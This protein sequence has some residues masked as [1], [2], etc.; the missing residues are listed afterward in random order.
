MTA[1]IAATTPAADPAIVQKSAA[2]TETI[3]TAAYGA[4]LPSSVGQSRRSLLNEF[5]ERSHIQRC[6]VLQC[7]AQR[8][9][10]DQ[11]VGGD[12]HHVEAID[13]RHKVL[14]GVVESTLLPARGAG[15]SSTPGG[16]PG[17]NIAMQES[18]VQRWPHFPADKHSS[19]WSTH[20]SRY[21]GAHAWSLY[22]G[23]SS[24]SSR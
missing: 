13:E 1:A 21:S 20:S 10:L 6:T 7:C 18:L 9:V 5:G 22:H 24:V 4:W 23:A 3:A 8:H 12:A 14:H 11:V 15:P 16:L 2:A 17:P 19:S